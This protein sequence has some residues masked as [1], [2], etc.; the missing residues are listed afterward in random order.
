VDPTH[1]GMSEDVLIGDATGGEVP[2]SE[3]VLGRRRFNPLSQSVVDALSSSPGR[4]GS[5]AAHDE[6]DSEETLA[7]YAMSAYQVRASGRSFLLSTYLTFFMNCALSAADQGAGNR[8]HSVLALP[9][10]CLLHGCGRPQR[11]RG[12]VRYLSSRR[13]VPERQR[14][15]QQR[16]GRATGRRQC[17]N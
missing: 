7:E 10:C 14:R 9:K 5:G 11:C 16:Y 3:K 1:A 6:G 4:R 2:R 13:Y 15:S 12:A 8:G 17:V